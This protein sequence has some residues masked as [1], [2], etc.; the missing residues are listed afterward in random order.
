M[1]RRSGG[2]KG[3]RNGELNEKEEEEKVK[4]EQSRRKISSHRMTESVLLG[5][6]WWWQTSP[7]RWEGCAGEGV[8]L[9]VRGGWGGGGLG[10]GGF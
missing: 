3:K 9:C 1:S 10:P 7:R 4:G 6:T 2:G 8:L 5:P